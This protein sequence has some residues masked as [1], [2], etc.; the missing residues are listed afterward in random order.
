MNYDRG[1][2]LDKHIKVVVVFARNTPVRK[3]FLL[4]LDWNLDFYFFFLRMSNVITR[5]LK[6]FLDQKMLLRSINL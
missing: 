2:Y 3:F 4:I 1:N 5:L 6:K